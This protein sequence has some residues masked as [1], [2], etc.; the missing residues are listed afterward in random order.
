MKIEFDLNL[1]ITELDDNDEIQRIL[2]LVM[3]EVKSGS[4]GEA[5]TD[6]KGNHI[7]YWHY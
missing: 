5:I 3:E 4:Q 6:F 1:A 7:G 2:E